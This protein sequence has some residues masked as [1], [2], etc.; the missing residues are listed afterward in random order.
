M[1]CNECCKES[2]SPLDMKLVL[3]IFASITNREN[4]TGLLR[5][6]KAKPK[7]AICRRLHA[8]KRY[9]TIVRARSS[10]LLAVCQCHYAPFRKSDKDNLVN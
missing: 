3:H 9:D 6:L 1:N 10:D 8:L 7:H 5:E 4:I 2:G